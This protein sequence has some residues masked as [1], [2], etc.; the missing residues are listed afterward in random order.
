VFSR[1]AVVL[2]CLP[3][4]AVAQSTPTQGTGEAWSI[5]APAQSNLVFARDGALIGES[6]KE[7]RTNIAL[8][9]LPHYVAQAFIAVEDQR[10]YQHDGVDLVGIAGALADAVRGRP[11]GASTITQLLVGNMHPDIIDRRD[12][13]AM[14]KLREQ[15]AAREME[16]HYTKQ[17]ILEAFLNQIHFGRSYY[18]IESAARHYFGKPASRLTIPEAATLAAMPKGPA[19][20]DPVRFPARTKTRRDLVLRLMSEQGYLTAD[21]VAAARAAPLTTVEYRGMAAPA[22]YFVDVV[23]IQASR[24]YPKIDSAG[25]FRVYTTVDPALQRAA[26]DA[27]R[28]VAAEVEHRPGYRNPVYDSTARR[29]GDYLQ[30]VVVAMDPVTGAVR[31]LVGGRDYAQSQFNRAVDGRR[32]PGS[33]FKPFVYAAAVAESLPPNE[34]VADTA[35]TIA[36]SNRRIYRPGNADGEFLGAMTMRNSLT[37]SRNPVAVSL[38]ERVGMDTV[39]ALARAAGIS[40]PISS[41]PSSAIGAS[42]VQP[43]DLV[44]AYSVFANGGARVEPRFINRIEDDKGRV[45]WQNRIVVPPRVLDPRVAF[46]VRDMMRDVVDRGT[47]NSVRRY[48]NATVPVAGKTGTTDNNVDVW[49]VGMTQDLVAGVWLGFD[50][51]KT[52]ATGAAGGGLAAPVFGRM[53]Q[54][55]GPTRAA[56]PWLPPAGLVVADLDRESGQ[57]AT[58]ATPS[59]R[60]YTEYFLDGTEP[61]ELRMNLWRL[62]RGGRVVF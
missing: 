38:A 29:A 40:S 50:K 55:A 20:Y 12:R 14:R 16:R 25:G 33:S 6:G 18:G 58:D 4:L 32:Q 36:M 37:R 9:S 46:I 19:L 17:Q 30:G 43:L 10:F 61:I 15:Q 24:A 49:F 31:A 54:L 57:L 56:A 27:L 13:S 47:A 21:Q 45:V 59:E 7:W 26:Y 52:I 42:V 8:S 11:R 44:A 23:R 53:L 41:F 62:V 5:V 51:P 1:I 22:E 2:F 28:E 39:I 60:R 34:I 48:V 35:L 3:A